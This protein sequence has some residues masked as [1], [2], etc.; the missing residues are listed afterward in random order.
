[1][2]RYDI[3]AN[4]IRVKFFKD[5]IVLIESQINDWLKANPDAIIVDMKFDSC[6]Y[7]NSSHSVLI[8]YTNHK[9]EW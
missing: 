5:G 1:M 9:K 6:G 8:I 2:K 7:H 3:S 4:D